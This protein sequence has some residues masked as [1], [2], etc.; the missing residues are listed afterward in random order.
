MI[1]QNKSYRANAQRRTKTAKD[2]IVIHYTANPDTSA[3]N[4]AKYFANKSTKT[5]A[6]YVVDSTSIYQCVE[7][8]D[9]AI[10]AGN[11]NDRSIGIELCCHKVNKSRLN[12]ADRDWYFDDATVKNAVELVKMLVKKYNIK[13]IIRHYDATGKTCPAPYVHDSNAWNKFLNACRSNSNP[14][15]YYPTGDA[16]KVDGGERDYICKVKVKVKDLNIR[17]GPGTTHRIVGVIKDGGTFRITDIKG[18]WGYLYS[19][20]G[21]INIGP[22]YCERM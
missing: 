22:K 9:V 8:K 3:K 14:W 17:K 20:S 2:T 16:V 1:T 4:N 18:N 13:R 19:N 6:H 11:Y 5:S 7:D 10:H 15:Q 21:W 12:A